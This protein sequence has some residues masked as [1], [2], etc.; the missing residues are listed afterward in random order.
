[1]H[2]EGATASETLRQT[3]Y[4]GRRLWRAA[5]KPVHRR[6]KL[7]QGPVHLS[8]FGQ[9]RVVT[10]CGPQTPPPDETDPEREQ[11]ETES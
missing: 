9:R 3:D 6:G 5:G 7:D 1:M 11:M 10:G 2:A 4:R 8:G